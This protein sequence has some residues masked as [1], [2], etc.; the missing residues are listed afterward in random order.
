MSA[1]GPV[2]EIR[3]LSLEF[4]V[5][6]G[7]V[8][9]L[10]GISLHVMPGEI[11]GVVGE[12]G[13]GKSV[14]A[15]A[16]LR[17]LPPGGH[18]VTAGRLS[19]C[20]EDVLAA[21]E[22]RMRQWR[23]HRAAMIFQEPMT[24]LNP[25]RRIGDQ[26]TGVLRAHHRLGRREALARAGAL[27]RDMMIPDP[28]RT[29]RA[30]P[31]ELSGGMRQRVMTAMA[32]SC[33][34]A[35]L[36]ADEPTT[37]LD[38]T[39]QRQVL[40]LLRHRA[41]AR[42]AAILFITHDMAVVSQFCDRVYVMYA[43]TVVEQGPTGQVLGAPCHPY[44]RGLLDGLPERAVPGAGLAAIPGRVPD[45]R[46]PPRGC[47]FFDRCAFADEACRRPPGLRPAADAAPG[48]AVACWHPL[49]PESAAHGQGDA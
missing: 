37:A 15:M 49:V 7:A 28:A 45:M 16:A 38:V 30:Y 31:F 43:G 17:L 22:A 12:S 48:A 39:V 9:A 29:L 33:D 32:F 40:Q 21:P 41:R 25:T 44:T 19:L 26:L 35:L 46:H 24:A 2:L 11:V 13:S 10:A 8:R 14:T 18:R 3:D 20:G 1:P 34:P 27:L 36:I 5:F 23:G 47:V 4:P 6:G 42:G